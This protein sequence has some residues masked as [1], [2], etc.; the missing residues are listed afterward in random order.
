[1][2]SC[3]SFSVAVLSLLMLSTLFSS[4]WQLKGKINEAKKLNKLCKCFSYL[5]INPAY[6]KTDFQTS[7]SQKLLGNQENPFRQFHP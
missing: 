6:K 3:S 2:V 4:D 1:M 5:D 7:L